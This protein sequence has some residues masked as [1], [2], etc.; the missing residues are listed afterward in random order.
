[1][2]CKVSK[3]GTLAQGTH[4]HGCPWSGPDTCPLLQQNS[5]TPHPGTCCK[6]PQLQA[7]T[8]KR[9]PKA[10]QV[11]SQNASYN[12]QAL[13]NRN[14][15][16]MDQRAQTQVS[17]C[18]FWN[19]EYQAAQWASG[20]AVNAEGAVPKQKQ[21]PKTKSRTMWTVYRWYQYNCSSGAYENTKS[22]CCEQECWNTS[23]RSTERVRFYKMSPLSFYTAKTI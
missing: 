2:L 3:L 11:N 9:P 1:M 4:L 21:C 6:I 18:S 22:Q 19:W 14:D 10:S 23:G 16:R 12:P 7:V 13:T 8:S 20:K 15:R 5:V 17:L